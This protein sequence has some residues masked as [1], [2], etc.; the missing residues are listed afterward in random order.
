MQTIELS[1]RSWL[2]M[3]HFYDAL[4]DA[5]GSFEAH[6]R[7]PNAFCETMIY[8]L[9]LNS[10]QPPYEVVITGAHAFLKPS[11][12][13]FASWVEEARTD[14]KMTPPMVTTWT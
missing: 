6:G 1:G 12:R 7:N 10:V 9:D 2:T 3:K 13:E 11:L 8:C 14:R 5:L 4:A